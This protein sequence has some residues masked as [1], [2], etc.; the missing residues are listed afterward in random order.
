VTQ[1]ASNDIRSYEVLVVGAGPAGTSAALRAAELGARVGLIEAR[2]TGGT[3]VNTGCV[4]T[5]VLAKTAR[6]VREV[7]AA[8]GYGI[9]VGDPVVDWSR[10]VARVRPGDRAHPHGQGRARPARRPRRRPGPRR[11]CPLHRPRHDGA[12]GHRS[13]GAGRR[14]RALRGRALPPP[15]RARRR[16]GAGAGAGARHARGAAPPARRGRPGT[17]APSWSPCSRPSAR[18]SPCWRWRPASSRRWTTT[19]PARSRTAS[20]PTRSTSGWASRSW[21]RSPASRATSAGASTRPADRW[22]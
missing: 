21:S 5:R 4:P 17:P 12:V 8:G 2:R 16:A 9:D 19:S 11:P 13:P 1:T 14:G 7:R 6:F 20:R 10:T 18:R 22:R 15:A 3:C